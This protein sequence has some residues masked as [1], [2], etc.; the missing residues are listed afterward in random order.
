M[1]AE[2]NRIDTLQ[3]FNHFVVQI[4]DIAKDVDEENRR[5]LVLQKIQKYTSER[6]DLEV[7]GESCEDIEQKITDLTL[8]DI[9]QYTK[10]LKRH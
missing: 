8:W 7:K 4:R 10:Y 1:Q 9:Q 6:Y 5:I 2:K 3:L